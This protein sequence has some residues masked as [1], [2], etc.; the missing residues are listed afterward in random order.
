MVNI[1]DNKNIFRRYLKI[2]TNQF[3]ANDI[4]EF[5]H[6]KK[7]LPRTSGLEVLDL[8]CGAGNYAL[9]FFRNVK[10]LDAIDSSKRMLNKFSQRLVKYKLGQFYLHHT[11]AENYNYPKSK[12]DLVF[13]TLLFHHINNIDEIFFNVNQSLKKDGLFLFSVIHPLFMAC[14]S[15]GQRNNRGVVEN[16]WVIQ[17]YFKKGARKYIW[18]GKPVIKYHHLFSDY[19]RAL[20]VNGFELVDVCEPVLARKYVGKDKELDE[21]RRNPVFLI[22][23]AK[24]CERR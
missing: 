4:I 22:F 6:I 8:G 10:R 15:M 24:K 7:L 14:R 20:K 3:N 17:N 9:K 23:L 5:P 19:L 11:K 16:E 21:Y 18:L 1:Y 13:S 2:R 12:Y